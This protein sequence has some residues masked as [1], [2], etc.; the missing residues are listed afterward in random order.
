MIPSHSRWTRDLIPLLSYILCSLL[1]TYPLVL[2]LSTHVP[3]EAT[4]DIPVY[5]WNLWW[6][7][8]SLLA[9][10][11]PLSSD[12]IFAPQ[13]VS[14]AFHPLVFVKAFLALPLLSLVS[15]WTAYNLLVLFTFSAAGYAMHLLARQ[16][17]GSAPAAWIAGLVYGFSPFMLARGQGHLNYLSSEWMP[18]YILCLLRLLATGRRR[19]AVGAGIFLLLTAYCEYYYLIYLTLFTFLYLAYRAWRAPA[20]I[21][22]RCF[23]TNFGLMGLIA[24]IGFSPI[25]WAL[26]RL[27]ESSYLYGGWS[28]SAKLGTDLLAF[29]APPPGSLLYGD[30][31][32]ALYRKFSGGNAMEGTVF[33]GYVVLGLVAWAIWRL[34]QEEAVR[35]WLWLALI[36]SL[37]SLGPLLHIGGDFVFGAGPVRFAVPLPYI[38][39]H[40]LPLIKGARVPARFDIMVELCLAVL[41]AFSLR[42]LLQRTARVWL[43]A[44]GIA[45]LI[46]LECFRLPYPTSEVSIPAIYRQIA[47]DERDVSVLEVPLGWRTGWETTGRSFD[48]QQL[49]QTVHGKR[50]IGGF[51]ARVPPSQ[52]EEMSNLPGV[53]GLLDL[54]E[55]I[56]IPEP[57]T[58]HRRL[59]IAR[60]MMELIEHLPDFAAARVMRDASVQKFLGGSAPPTALGAP[61]AEMVKGQGLEL[62]EQARLG[63]V[64][65]H[66]PYSSDREIIDYLKG[67]FSLEEFYE[68]DGVIGFRLVP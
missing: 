22:D 13:S 56:E 52:L 28:G 27:R 15:A 60:Q 67:C 2:R 3:G 7:R 36:Y 63:Y 62:V 6:V 10:I 68:E 53:R 37:L 61:S 16:L 65:A 57:P 23:L 38:A 44:L 8:E 50:L 54:Q 11:S 41:C 31:C 45:S 1:F 25:L 59:E 49:Y 46:A 21:L 42:T 40:Y 51:A 34:R 29:V 48:A 47:A 5:I 4:G 35:P 26:F 58:A 33:V 9:G 55:R 30:V 20:D 66:P 19:W 39:I 14:L 64:I 17:T 43:L 18:L 12:F 32:Q 24:A